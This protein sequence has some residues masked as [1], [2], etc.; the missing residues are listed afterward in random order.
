MKTVTRFL[1]ALVLL[2]ATCSRRRKAGS[3]PTRPFTTTRS[4]SPMKSDLWVVGAKGG[5][6]ARLTTFPGTESFAKFSP[7]GKWLAFTA[8]YDGA[9]AV[10]LM[11][12]EGGAP[13]RLTYNPGGAQVIAWTPD[14]TEVVFRSMFE[15][16]VG[17]D[18]NLY[19][20]ERQG[21]RPERAARST[22]ASSS[23]SSPKSTSSSIAAAATRSTTGSATRA[24]STRTSGSTTPWPRRI[25]PSRTTSARTAIRCG[26]A[27]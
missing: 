14:G 21:R 24:A 6:A 5:V 10:Y 12:A 19:S 4:P 17:R 11:P 7:D 18:P 22:A 1:I 27:A 13:V 15:N 8:T 2:S 16:V 23:A 20:V 3:S 9:Q 25:R 26:P